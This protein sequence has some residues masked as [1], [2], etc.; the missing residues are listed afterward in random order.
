MWEDFNNH[1]VKDIAPQI[2]SSIKA[3]E[4]E[5]NNY[6]NISNDDYFEM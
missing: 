1:G 6:K 4:F 5:K 2:I 3:G